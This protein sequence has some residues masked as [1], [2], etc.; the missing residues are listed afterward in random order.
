[1]IL[2]GVLT[3]VGIFALAVLFAR[4]PRFDSSSTFYQAIDAFFAAAIRVGLIVAAVGIIIVLGIFWPIPVMAVGFV[5]LL[6]L[7]RY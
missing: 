4:G 5:F 7:A 2:L 6:S 1:M 3:I